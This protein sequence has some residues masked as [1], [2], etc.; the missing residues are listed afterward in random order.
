MNRPEIVS[1]G[2]VWDSERPTLDHIM[3]VFATLGTTLRLGDVFHSVVDARWAATTAH[4]LVGVVTYY[5]KHYSTFFFHTKL[6][7]WIYFDDATV[8]EVGPRWEQVVDKCRRG[9]YQPLLLLYAAPNG[10]PVSA[11]GAPKTI[12]PVPMG[13]VGPAGGS[14][15]A[16][17]WNLS[18]PGSRADKTALLRRSVTPNPDKT[19]LPHGPP[20]GLPNGLHNGHLN[21]HLNGL[22]NGLPNGMRRAVTPN[23]Q[24]NEYQNLSDMQAIIFGQKMQQQQQQ[25]VSSLRS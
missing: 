15:P 8:R 7:V 4:S 22:P 9:R 17:T 10:S 11:E 20:N 24:P 16:P 18:L 21:G 23:S 5:G 3:S 12:T 14:G 13:P 19:G 25:N 6:R 2:V 1:V